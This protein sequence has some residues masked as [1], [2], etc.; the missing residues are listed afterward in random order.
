MPL[1]SLKPWGDI[2]RCVYYT[3]DLLKH[4]GGWIL[5]GKDQRG[6]VSILEE[7]KM[8]NLVNALQLG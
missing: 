5:R 7:V 3:G 6:R 2:A 1:K 4:G 8:L